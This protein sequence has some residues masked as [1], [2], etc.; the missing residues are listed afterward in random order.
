MLNKFEDLV[1]SEGKWATMRNAKL[2]EKSWKISGKFR[3]IKFY[4]YCIQS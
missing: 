4:A 2:C 1:Q 3:K